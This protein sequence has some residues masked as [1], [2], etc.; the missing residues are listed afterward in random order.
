MFE[1]WA[2]PGHQIAPPPPWRTW[3]ILGG[4]GSGKTRAGAEWVRAVVEGSTPLQG[5][6]CRRVALI[7]E[8]VDQA[9]EVMIEGP[10]GILAITPEDRRP[11]YQASR[12]RLEW[13]NGAEAFVYSAL[14]PEAL[15]GPQFDGAWC[16]ELAKWKKGRET[17]DQLQFGLRLGKAPRQVVTTTPR[18][19]ELLA[20][21]LM[22][23]DTVAASAPTEANR[24]NLAPG[25]LQA[26]EARFGGSAIARQ[27]L[28]GEL[29]DE[30]PGALWTRA[31]IEACRGRPGDMARIVVAVDP[32][33][34]VGETADE[35]GIVVAGL[36]DEGLVWVLEDSTCRGLSPQGWAARAVDAYDRWSAD[37]IVAEVNQ[38]GAMIEALV[39]GERSDVAYKAV[40]ASDGKRVRAEPVAAAYERG[41]VR[42]ARRF[43]ALEDQMCGFDGRRVG[44]SPD[45]VDA[46]VWAVT[47]LALRPRS[48]APR[49][50][51]L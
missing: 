29:L 3:L 41:D 24:A 14:R 7:A 44:R 47:E 13:P 45:R 46:L 34:T 48:A 36:D 50:R 22:A 27:E 12:K 1:V 39:R 40:R 25:F 49:A 38:G 17:W 35:C 21:I 23:S 33:A 30:A 15:R 32:P 37:R 19:S 42:H 31:G 2:L 43:D 6:E 10:S 51:S 5:G 9:R 8:T 18:R 11:K 26:A 16:D 28:M 4:R 20:D